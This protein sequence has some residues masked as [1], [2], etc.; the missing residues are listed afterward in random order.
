VNLINNTEV[1]YVGLVQE[2]CT[3]IDNRVLVVLGVAMF[4][5][6]VEPFIR[7]KMLL[8][9]EKNKDKD[10]WVSYVFTADFVGVVWKW[11][12]L[13]LIFIAGYTMW[14]VSSV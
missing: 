8:F 12:G 10:D 2:Y 14:I 6:I 1:D 7:K 5:W 3:A 9:E 11:I 13:G 4:M